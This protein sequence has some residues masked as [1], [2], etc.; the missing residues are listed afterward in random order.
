MSG[1]IRLHVADLEVFKRAQSIHAFWPLENRREVDLRPLLREA[2][3]RG[4]QVWLP[5]VSGERLVHAPYDSDDSLHRGAFGVMEP[6]VEKA[7]SD[8]QPD[9]ILL[10]AMA[11]DAAGRRLGYGGGYYDR[12]LADLHERGHF[13]PLL[14]AAFSLQ[15]VE[16]VPV[17]PFDVPA[18]G[19]ASEQG[20]QWHNSRQDWV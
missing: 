1:Q 15:I 19:T 17:E 7:L 10:P 13:P 12:F 5:I 4:K 6:S 11:M 18:D 3:Q 14:A 2:R 8:I 9:L 20:I 16:R